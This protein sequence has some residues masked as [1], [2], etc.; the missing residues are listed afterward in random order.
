MQIATFAE[1]NVYLS[2][3]F[4]L[5]QCWVKYALFTRYSPLFLT[6]LILDTLYK[7]QRGFFVKLNLPFCFSFVDLTERIVWLLKDYV[8][9]FL[10]GFIHE[11]AHFSVK[12]IA[13]CFFVDLT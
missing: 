3:T 11:K 8:N 7:V 5:Y 12:S 10:D 9:V 4:W 13:I 2:N 6:L 1:K